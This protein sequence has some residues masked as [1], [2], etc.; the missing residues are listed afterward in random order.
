MDTDIRE[1]I[2]QFSKSVCNDLTYTEL[3]SG[4]IG[5]TNDALDKLNCKKMGKSRQGVYVCSS[6]QVYKS[7]P[8]NM[9]A[10]RIDTH[11][12]ETIKVDSFTMNII[13]QSIML[14][15]IDKATPGMKEL[16]EYIEHPL[17]ICESSG[18]IV[19]IYNASSGAGLTKS[20]QFSR[21]LLEGTQDDPLF[22]AN[23][24]SILK[25]VFHINDFLYDMCQF[26]HCD[27]KCEQILL[28]T[29]TTGEIIP[30]LSDFDKSTCTIMNSND[31]PYR[32][33][34]VRI[35]NFQDGGK[36]N[37]RTRKSRRKQRRK[38]KTQ[39]KNR[40]LIHK[41]KKNKKGGGD[42]P[43]LTFAD[44]V[45][46][47]SNKYKQQGKET[48][49]KVLHATKKLDDLSISVGKRKI[50]LS[51]LAIAYGPQGLQRFKDFPLKN[52]KYY[53]LCLLASTL[54]QISH[55]NYEQF[56]VHVIDGLVG[57]G[58]SEY[59]DFE[60]IERER[61]KD[62]EKMAEKHRRGNAIAA[63]CIRSDTLLDEN[64]TLKSRLKL[65][66]NT[67]GSFVFDVKE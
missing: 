49:S 13:Q 46:S 21:F 20:R 6:G 59:I 39:R 14:S 54:L 31:K 26:Q 57:P 34:L 53:N 58:Y 35:E 24:I 65:I 47:F 8:T 40:K 17:K 15:I 36:K 28:N 22:R 48:L 11:G 23:T 5:K 7:H 63:E 44:K 45:K 32:I 29:D 43:K 61:Q 50:N 33:R 42:A 19:M 1:F 4:L 55:S 18:S 2:T 27:M 37:Q 52:N 56:K 60:K 10:R 51:P 38:R 41:Y 16:A 3:D 30:I 66:K 25:K 12:G 62:G 9:E 64:K 67:S